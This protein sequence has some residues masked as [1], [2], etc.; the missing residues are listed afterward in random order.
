MIKEIIKQWEDRKHLLEQYFKDST[1]SHSYSSI[2]NKLFEIV[3]TYT[4]KSYPEKFDISKMTVIDDGD[5]QGTA[6]YI[7]P[8]DT[9]Q[10]NV[11]NYIFT[12]NYYGS[13]SGCDTIQGINSDGD[14]E[15]ASEEQVRDYM[16]VALHL[17]QNMKYLRN[18]N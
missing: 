6:I 10:P 1:P 12:N 4:G 5:Y 11:S 2:L 18:E 17:V 15:T 8:E 3:I 16:T 9:Y 13:C 7:I 14:Y